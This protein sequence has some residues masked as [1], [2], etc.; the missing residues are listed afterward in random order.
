MTIAERPAPSAP[1]EYRFP[2]VTRAV[3]DNGLRVVVA[4]VHKLPVVT[5]LMVVSAGSSAEPAGKEGVAALT[6]KGLLEG[7]RRHD[8]SSLT[9]RLEL[10]GATLHAHSDWDT[11]TIGMTVLRS[12][13]DEALA[14]FGEVLLEPAFPERELERLK[15]ERLAELLQLETEPR[16]L[17]DDA[18]TRFLYEP[19]S[20]YA[21][22]EDGSSTSVEALRR[23]DARAFYGARYRAGGMTLVVAGDVEP[24]AMVVLADQVL[25]RTP[26]GTPP[27]PTVVDRPARLTRA[28]HIVPKDDAPQ[29][30]LRIGHVGLPRRHPDYF[31]VLVMN[32]VLGGLFSSRINLNLREVHAYTY[33]ASSG[34]EWRLGA[35]PFLVSTAVRSDVTADAMREVLLEIDRMRSESVKSEELSLATSYLAGVFPIR[36]ETTDAIARALAAAVMYQLPPDYFDRY[37]DRVRAVTTADVIQAAEHHL[38]PDQLQ[39]V[40]V[41]DPVLIRAP[42]EAL[43][44]GEMI[45]HGRG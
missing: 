9:E 15:G 32:A 36:Y 25:A 38:H 12:R 14:L 4:P 40:V 29:S 1:R 22:P 21:A 19:G 7:T 11:A 6:A 30:E 33:G 23:E 43:G 3:L 13:L 34:F 42:L 8:G 24:D 27:A 39:M 28:V 17:A 31:P 5:V 41:G 18:F 37:R 20:R 35:G 45:V 26:P 2:S 10:L 44:A 16:G